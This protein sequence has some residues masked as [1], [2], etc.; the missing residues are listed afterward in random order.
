IGRFYPP[1]AGRPRTCGAFPA[2]VTAARAGLCRLAARAP[3]P[4]LGRA[5]RLVLGSEAA[6]RTERRRD[7]DAALD[8]SGLERR[9][10]ASGSGPCHRSTGRTPS[11]GGTTLRAR[12]PLLACGAPA[13]GGGRPLLRGGAPL[14][15]CG[16]PALG[17]GR[18]LLRGGT[19]LLGRGRPLLRGGAPALG[20]GRPLLRGGAP[21]L[22]CGAPALGGGRPLL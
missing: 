14:I 21:L 12:R 9:S 17:R 20:R 15:A 3:G 22:A 1:K 13:L 5:V 11:L 8:R 18:P 7:A 6:D 16:A 2:Y 4:L 19:P 10:R